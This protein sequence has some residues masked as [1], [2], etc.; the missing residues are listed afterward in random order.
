[1]RLEI[2]LLLMTK[3]S[4]VRNHE[5]SGRHNWNPPKLKTDVL[6]G[7]GYR[8]LIGGYEQWWGDDYREDQIMLRETC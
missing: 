2:I 7:L 4:L 6:F 1:M 3:M 5:I 8:T